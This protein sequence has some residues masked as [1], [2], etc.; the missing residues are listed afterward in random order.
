[1]N[2]IVSAKMR[3]GNFEPKFYPFIDMDII[4]KIYIVRKERGPDLDKVEYIVL[5][6]ICRFTFFN[7]IFTPFI[8]AYQ[9]RKKKAKLI[10]SYHIVPHAFFAFFAGLITRT[11]FIIG[12][13]G[14]KI[15][16]LCKR[17]S[18]I[19]TITKLILKKAAFINVPGE[20]SKQVWVSMGIDSPKI[21][22][23][24]SVIDTKKFKSANQSKE[25]DYIFVGAL[26]KRKRVDLIIEAFA[27]VLENHP[28]A[29]LLIVGDGE[30]KD[31][32]ELK[33]KELGI[34][35]KIEFFGYTRDI[36]SLLNKAKIS[37]MASEVEGLPVAM[38]E[39][40]A[41]EL[42]VIAP[43]VFN[44]SQAVK[45]KETGFLIEEINASQLAQ[46]LDY[47]LTNYDSLGYIRINA[48][49]K[50]IAEHSVESAVKKWRIILEDF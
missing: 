14:G 25:Y 44:I 43:D 3:P 47:T 10:L 36:N 22:I 49:K 39:A 41:C 4:S 20:P 21:N 26:I 48:R 12:Q 33:A 40:M 16:L 34:D 37:V 7:L 27:K 6:S 28:N 31:S 32:L 19:R 8:L 2:I 46:L 42:I 5:P 35:Q 24:H 23:L 15:E 29:S 13:T 17:N 45:H 18:I 9:T 11:P 30:E 1:M 50:I 38:M